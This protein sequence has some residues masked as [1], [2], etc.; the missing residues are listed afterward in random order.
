MKADCLWEISRICISL[1]GTEGVL[2]ESPKTNPHLA[3]GT[4]RQMEVDIT[5]E[6]AKVLMAE[7]RTAIEQYED[8]EKSVKG[9]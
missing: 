3:F 5:L 6:E 1:N 9:S 7:L 4:V 2:F 8:L